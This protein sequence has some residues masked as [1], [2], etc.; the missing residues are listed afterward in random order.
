[1]NIRKNNMLYNNLI[2]ICK[3]IIGP[4]APMFLDSILGI[5]NIKK[6]EIKNEDLHR[7]AES[8]YARTSKYTGLIHPIHDDI[9]KAILALSK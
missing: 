2:T 6:E 4:A 7:I 3:D 9:K 1:M 8:A 5:L